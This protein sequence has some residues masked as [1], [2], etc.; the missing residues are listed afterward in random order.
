MKIRMPRNPFSELAQNLEGRSCREAQIEEE[1]VGRIAA[2]AASAP[3][4]RRLHA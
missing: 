4:R 3:C 2:I 1:H